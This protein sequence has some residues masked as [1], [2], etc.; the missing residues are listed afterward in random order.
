MSFPCSS[1]AWMRG[2]SQLFSEFRLQAVFGFGV[3]PSGGLWVWSSAFRRSLGLEF[4]LQAVFGFGVPPSG[5]L[6]VAWDYAEY[7]AA[8]HG[9]AI[10]ILSGVTES[11]QI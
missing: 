8:W 4:R 7:A 9:G 1:T 2:E 10:I 3:P 6:W 5:G 11:G